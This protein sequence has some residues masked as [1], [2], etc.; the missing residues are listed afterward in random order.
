MARA[1]TTFLEAKEEQGSSKVD[2]TK[3]EGEGPLNL[4]RKRPRFGAH[5][6]HI[7]IEDNS[8]NKEDKEDTTKKCNVST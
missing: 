2:H 7:I 8:N 3:E 1:D 5:R 6:L 4:K